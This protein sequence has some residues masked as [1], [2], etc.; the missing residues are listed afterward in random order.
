MLE[1]N[2]LM[3]GVIQ[4]LFV[5]ICLYLLMRTFFSRNNMT[6]REIA[7]KQNFS[8]ESSSSSVKS[9]HFLYDDDD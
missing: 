6:S 9:N 7:L 5:K 1:N 4:P 8:K 2:S 3:K